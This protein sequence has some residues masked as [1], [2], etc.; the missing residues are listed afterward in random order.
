MGGRFF[1]GLSSAGWGEP[2]L[3]CR[4]RYLERTENGLRAPVF[5]EL[6]HQDP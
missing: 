3:F 6:L 5:L 2:G 1:F 4:V